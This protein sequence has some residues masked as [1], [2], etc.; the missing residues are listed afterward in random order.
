[1]SPRPPSPAA[2]R[3]HF[4]ALWLAAFVL[5]LAAVA[6]F[7]RLA[8]PYGLYEG[9]RWTAFNALKARPDLTL[10]DI[11]LASALRLR[12][13]AVILG[14]SRADIGFDPQ[15]LA[16]HGWGERPYNLAV[17]GSGIETNLHQLRTLLDQGVVPRRLLVGVEF[18]DYLERRG[19]GPGR[20]LTQPRPWPERLLRLRL[21]GLFTLTAL[22]DSLA[23]VA[24]QHRDDTPVLRG[25]G[26]NP[27]REYPTLA[28]KE[29]YFSLFRQRGLENA[30]RLR[31]SRPPADWEDTHD[32]RALERLLTLA[33]E[34]DIRVDL[35]VYPYH[36]QVIGLFARYDLL[37]AFAAWK[38]ALVTLTDRRAT[39]GTAVRLWD[40][41][42]LDERTTE[43]IPPRNDKQSVTRWYWE[44]GHFKAAL[45]DEIL[46][47]IREEAPA[48]RLA[49]PR[50]R[51]PDLAPT[52]DA[53]L[54]SRADLRDDLDQ[55][56]TLVQ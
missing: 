46:R 51:P 54:S 16:A 56:V 32:Y 55:I 12:P 18:L 4:A 50:Q 5:A 49:P 39:A 31:D 43:A 47:R 37:P 20:A 14:N 48:H 44:A 13:D 53:L 1:M 6:A 38:S 19:A 36:A 21:Q 23:T 28:R 7:T 52:L 45:G 10:G 35:V 40:F 11:K 26:F 25:D 33:A 3:R 17:P 22:K 27:L 41:S 30:R 34:R 2:A 29:G 8:D 9:P 24:A 42:G 15:S